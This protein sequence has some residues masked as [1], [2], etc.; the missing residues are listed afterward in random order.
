MLEQYPLEERKLLYRVL[1]RQLTTTP[2]L[3]DGD[4]LSDLQLSLQRLAQ[5]DGV[6]ISDH[7]AWDAW[8]GNAAVSCAVRVSQRQ[9]FPTK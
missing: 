3:M 1:H 2:E 9:T 7:G 6:D 8:V 5:A 4:F